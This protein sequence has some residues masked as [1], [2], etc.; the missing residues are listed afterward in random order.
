MPESPVS[1]RELASSHFKAAYDSVLSTLKS[2][3]S[4]R[5]R[6]LSG[7]H[8][9]IWREEEEKQAAARL[10]EQV[11]EEAAKAILEIKE[12]AQRRARLEQQSAVERS[13]SHAAVE[14]EAKEQLVPP[15]PA[16]PGS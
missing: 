4:R 7:L 13:F 12:E 8:A 10:E 11:A 15:P 3:G 9:E 6:S 16:P 1:G 2:L 5:C 14:P